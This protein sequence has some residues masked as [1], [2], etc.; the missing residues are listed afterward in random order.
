MIVGKTAII[1][2]NQV[3]PVS[4]A[5]GGGDCHCGL[6]LVLLDSFAVGAIGTHSV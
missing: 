1:R 4:S 2:W 5:T 6:S 3:L